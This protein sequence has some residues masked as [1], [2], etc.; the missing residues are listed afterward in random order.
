MLGVIRDADLD[1]AVRQQTGPLVALGVF[2]VGN[3]L[4]HGKAP[5]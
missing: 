3:D 2:Q 5:Q 4:A 1:E